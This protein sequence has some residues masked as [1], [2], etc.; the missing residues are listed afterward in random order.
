MARSQLA[1]ATLSAPPLERV[2]RIRP[3]PE[4]SR[5]GIDG[6]RDQSVDL[7]GDRE[8]VLGRPGAQPP[9]LCGRGSQRLALTLLRQPRFLS[10]SQDGLGRCPHHPAIGQ[11]NGAQDLS[12]LFREVVRLL[13]HSDLR[14]NLL[15]F[16]ICSMI[17]DRRC[18]RAM[19]EVNMAALVSR[20]QSL[21]DQLILKAEE[22]FGPRS[23]TLAP[24]VKPWDNPIPET[25]RD[26]PDACS[27]YYA[28]EAESND[29]LLRFQLA[30]EAIHV[31]SG[32]LK[33]EAR[34]LEEGFAVWFSLDQVRRHYRRHARKLLPNLFK[35]ALELFCQLK[36][37]DSKIKE[38]RSECPDL[39]D[40]RAELLMRIFLVSDE[41]AQK[42][43]E[44]VPFERDARLV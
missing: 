30:H 7:A 23:Y 21:F 27:V 15:I 1:P 3:L 44:R 35:R 41:Q 37:T 4:P 5:I 12:L 29:Q 17:D 40:A 22:R 34:K 26:R 36:P 43:L 6:S 38:L 33:R 16:F 19:V 31:L 18:Q 32:A 20:E 42:I 14:S 39:N 9:I 13:R 2:S 28:R 24:T 8:L 11:G 25:V 10:T